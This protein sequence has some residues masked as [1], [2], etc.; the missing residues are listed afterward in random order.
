MT[1]QDFV[2]LALQLTTMLGC[3]VLFGEIMRRFKQ[4]AVVGEMLGGIVLGPT[5]FGWL[6]RPSPPRCRCAPCRD[7]GLPPLRRLRFV[8]PLTIVAPSS[9]DPSAVVYDRISAGMAHH[10]FIIH[11]VAHSGGYGPAWRSSDSGSLRSHCN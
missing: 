1:S 11:A 9:I 4:P 8:C 3:A 6:A 5:V 10:R 2:K 7:R